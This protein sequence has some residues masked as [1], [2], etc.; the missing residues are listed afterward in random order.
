MHSRLTS[1]L[2]SLHASQGVNPFNALVLLRFQ[3][4]THVDRAS[5]QNLWGKFESANMVLTPS[6]S[7]NPFCCGIWGIVSSCQILSWAKYVPNSVEAYSP[8]LS[9]QKVWSSF[10]WIS[11]P[12]LSTHKISEILHF[13]TAKYR[14]ICVK[15]NESD[16]YLPP[17]SDQVPIFPHTS[18]CISS[19]GWPTLS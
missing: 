17:S 5:A 13:C 9:E 8:P 1:G 3:R 7:A 2:V 15:Y 19:S 16:K 4:Y 6:L 11:Q 10:H 14:P 18:L 12:G